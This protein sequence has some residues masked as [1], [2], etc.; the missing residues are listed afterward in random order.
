M[1]SSR[2]RTPFALFQR[3]KARWLDPEQSIGAFRGVKKGNINCWSAEGPAKEAFEHIRSEIAEALER[4]CG[5][6]PSSSW[7][8]F[9]IFMVGGTKSTAVPHIMFSCKRPEP[10]KAAVAALKRSNILDECPPGIHL[11]HWDCPPHLKDLRFLASATRYGYPDTYTSQDCQPTLSFHN[12]ELNSVPRIYSVGSGQA[13]QLALKNTSIMPEYLRK[14][15]IGSIVS[16]SDRQFYLAPAHFYS[17]EGQYSLDMAP[18]EDSE[19]ED[20]ECEFGGLDDGSEEL[21]NS[22]EVDFMS[23]YSLT[24]GSSNLEE[25]LDFDEHDSASDSKSDCLVFEV[26][27]ERLSHEDSV[28][29]DDAAYSTPHN[30]QDSSLL[31]SA[32]TE[33]EA[34]YLKSAALDYC[35]I[36]MKTTEHSPPDLPIFARENIGQVQ[37]GSV[38][39]QAAT[40]SGNI[41]KGVLYSGLSCVRPPNETRYMNVLSAQFEGPLQPGDSG[42]IV[43]DTRTGIIYGHIIAGDTSSQIALIIPALEVLNDIVRKFTYIETLS[44]GHGLSKIPLSTLPSAKLRS[45]GNPDRQSSKLT[46]N[47]DVDNDLA[48]PAMLLGQHE[49]GAGAGGPLSKGSPGIGNPKLICN[50]ASVPPDTISVS[51]TTLGQGGM[52]RQIVAREIHIFGMPVHR[53]H[54]EHSGIIRKESS[55]LKL[56]FFEQATE[57]LSQEEELVLAMR[58]LGQMTEVIKK[59]NKDRVL[60]ARVVKPQKPSAA[61]NNKKQNGKALF[62][63]RKC[64][65]KVRQAESLQRHI[66][67]QHHPRAMIRCPSPTCEGNFRRKDKFRDHCLLIHKWLATNEETERY[68]QDLPCPP[69]CSICCKTVNDWESFYKCFTSHCYI[70]SL[71]QYEAAVSQNDD[72]DNAGP[73]SAPGNGLNSSGLGA[74]NTGASLTHGYNNYGD[75]SK[76]DMDDSHRSFESQ[77]RTENISQGERMIFEADETDIDF[78]ACFCLAEASMLPYYS[79]CDE[80]NGL[81]MALDHAS[82]RD[83]N[84]TTVSL[85]TTPPS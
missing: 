52:N 9:D 48:S 36:E 53:S 15:T 2:I 75:A 45:Y 67:D 3:P 42:S 51:D 61:Q 49:A 33:A 37:S 78:P 17:P 32:S 21:S 28:S 57:N 5:P 13:L 74:G 58:H 39:V 71:S 70:Q 80:P 30:A 56:D 76:K 44:R 46:E 16:I 25:D 1:S 10:R 19:L 50:E 47:F 73:G 69:G 6:V 8:Q 43:R 12:N 11:G 31:G 41:L 65:T 18:E 54:T 4:H 40:G 59:D 27:A 55:S 85:S 29:N 81:G 72:T 24:P 26:Q 20:S 63:C 68:T 84:S 34:P 66:E 22:Q 64:G 38:N 62:Q 60:N 7:V 14:A 35:L 79:A 77:R 82:A 83:S 23:Q